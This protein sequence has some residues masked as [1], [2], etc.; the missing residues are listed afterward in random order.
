MLL[1]LGSQLIAQE[2]SCDGTV[3]YLG[4][5]TVVGSRLYQLRIEPLTGGLSSKEIVLD[6][7]DRRQLT[8]LGYNVRDRMLYALDFNTY[9]LIRI[10]SDGSLTVLGSKAI[11][12]QYAI[13][14]GGMSADGLRLLLVARN[15]STG[16]DE[17]LYAIRVN[18]PGQ[19][20]GSF[21]LNADRPVALVDMAIDPLTS[22]GYDFDESRRHLVETGTGGQVFTNLGYKELNE[23]FGSL[24]FDPAGHL[25]G[26][27]NAGA[28]GAEQ[29]TIYAINK[30]TGEVQ[31]YGKV[32]GGRD[33]DACACPYSLDF[34]RDISPRTTHGC[35]M[36][37]VTYRAFN[38]GGIGQLGVQ[39]RDTFPEGFVITEVHLPK[40]DLFLRKISGE[41]SNILA[42]DDWNLLM[43][44]NEITVRVA[45]M[46]STTGPIQTQAQ[47]ANL[48]AAYNYGMPSDDSR[49]E[50]MDDPNVLTILDANSYELEDFVQYSCDLDTAYLHLPL[51]G[52]YSWSTGSTDS[53]LAVTEDATYALTLTTPCFTV[54]D[55]IE[56]KRREEPYFVELGEARSV[57][58]GQALTFPFQHNL[59]EIKSLY[60][61]SLGDDSLTCSSCTTPV[62]TAIN[63]GQVRLTVTDARNCTF[64]DEVDY[65]VLQ[66]KNIYLPNVFSPNE[67]G[68]NDYFKP[69]GD[70]GTILDLLIRDRWGSSVFRYSGGDLDTFTGW[71]G[72]REGEDLPPGAYFYQ[73][74]IRFP[75]EEV[76][77]YQGSILLV[78]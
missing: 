61:Q 30:W 42:I 70:R 69:L 18:D 28:S 53:V 64:S 49:T 56:Y 20:L 68:V 78:R 17:K 14:S 66:S 5:N 47:L 33:T 13:Y 58:L 50:T 32:A 46:T 31:R 38:A 27:G 57:K 8:A 16:I 25:Y 29:T 24:F 40:E 6:N 48:Y 10:G 76:K 60:W 52:T 22:N 2:F 39:L 62:L 45:L 36:I 51:S 54:R 23:V 59:A 26:L 7:P 11:D 44:D 1:L 71:D 72:K 41:G 21:P 73:L 67:D 15:K 37:T 63:G 55:T 34:T 3:Y 9:E 43:G 74:R 75:D 4:T 12:P 65:R 77:A 19:P 35:G